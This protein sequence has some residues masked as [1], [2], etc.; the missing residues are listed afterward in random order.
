MVLRKTYKIGVQNK[1]KKV[2]PL[3]KH[4]TIY[5]ESLKRL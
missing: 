5:S 1:L 4:F 3:D 2:D